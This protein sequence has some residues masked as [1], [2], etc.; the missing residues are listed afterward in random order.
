MAD[1]Y[2]KFSHK[3]DYRKDVPV[4]KKRSSIYKT[5]N[6]SL[7]FLPVWTGISG[8]RLTGFTG[9]MADWLSCSW[10]KS[11]DDFYFTRYEA[12]RI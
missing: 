4:L 12:L 3:Y 1:P 2:Y 5:A 9:E 6:L 11:K 10:T 7:S 8:S